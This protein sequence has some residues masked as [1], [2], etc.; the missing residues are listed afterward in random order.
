MGSL[1]VNSHFN[2][3]PLEETTAN[4]TESLYNQNY[5]VEGLK[6]NLCL[7]NFFL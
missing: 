2:N 7:K 1:D 3:I 6:V 4:C 5:T